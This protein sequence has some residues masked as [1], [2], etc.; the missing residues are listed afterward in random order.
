MRSGAVM[1]GAKNRYV[2]GRGGDCGLV[3]L[4]HRVA[5]VTRDPQLLCVTPEHFAEH[6]EVLRRL[7]RPARLSAIADLCIGGSCAGSVAITFDDGYADNLYNAKPILEQFDVTAT[8]FVVAHNRG[9]WRELWW[10]ELARITLGPGTLCDPLRLW[11][12]GREHV[13]QLDGEGNDSHED[14]ERDAGWNVL[15]G[16]QPNARQSLYQS[17]FDLLRPLGF[18]D[19]RVTLDSLS[20]QSTA[21]ML[22]LPETLSSDD[23]RALADGDLVEIGAHTLTHPMLAAL[24]IA[25]QRAEIEG[26]R[27]IL[28]DILGG[29]VRSFSYPF[30]GRRDYTGKTIRIV[31][32]AGF[33]R[34]CSN[35]SGVVSSSSDRFQVPRLIVRDWDGDTFAR[36]IAAEFARV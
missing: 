16:G 21:P 24:P 29:S 1:S 20:Q 17:L 26:S 15:S 28:Q 34:A 7:L 2:Y 33:D 31:R 19:R 23:L 3:L 32:E 27:R 22:A 10:D 13:W 6:M 18:D 12:A 35:F 8:V 14:S 4:Y 11:I 25:E 36:H 5:S 30:G 9:P